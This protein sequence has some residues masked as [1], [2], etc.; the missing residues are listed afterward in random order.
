MNE[1][2][3]NEIETLNNVPSGSE[4]PLL[5]SVKEACKLMNIGKNTMLKFVKMKGFPAIILPHKILI[6]KNE[7]PV[8]IRENYGRYKN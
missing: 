2:I 6:D 8:W 1:Q 4:P 5:I 3:R 7:L